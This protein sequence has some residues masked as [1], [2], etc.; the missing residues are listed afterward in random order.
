M[1]GENIALGAMLGNPTEEQIQE[2]A[3]NFAA[4]A[5]EDWYAEIKYY[6]FGDFHAGA[7]PKPNF[8]HFTQMVW[9]GTKE[10]GYGLSKCGNTYYVV[11]RY[12]PPGNIDVL[13][14]HL[15]EENV[16]PPQK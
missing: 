13:G 9:K 1:A 6:P 4:N 2:K 3:E 16:L 15:F 10:V 8:L 14:M 12:F 5:A 7:G 11:A